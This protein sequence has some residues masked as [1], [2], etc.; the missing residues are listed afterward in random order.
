MSFAWDGRPDADKHVLVEQYADI[1]EPAPDLSD[2]ADRPFTVGAVT[3]RH[4]RALLGWGW[5]YEDHDG[6]ARVQTTYVPRFARRI[7]TGH[8]DLLPPSAEEFEVME[9]L[10]RRAVQG[11][12]TAGYRTLRWSGPDTGPDGHAATALKAQG[13]TEYARTWSAEPATWQPSAGLPEVQ[14]EQLPEPGLT[15]ATENA[16]VSARIDGPT[17]Y[18]NAGEA[19]HHHAEPPALAALLAE[20]VTRLQRKHPEVTALTIWEFDDADTGLRQALSLAGLR[21]TARHMTYE[22]P[23]ASP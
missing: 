7:K 1:G 9:G 14:V 6:A 13:H 17:A 3:A 20:L 16:E 4:D 8:Y 11:A 2:G 22:L 15:L 21:I 19:I 12:R 23:L 18:I 10:Y 5:V